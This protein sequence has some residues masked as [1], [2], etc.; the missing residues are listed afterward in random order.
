MK[1]VD[2]WTSVTYV[3]GQLFAD[4]WTNEGCK[5]PTTEK[6]QTCCGL[7]KEQG[8]PYCKGHNLVGHNARM[9]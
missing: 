9:R 4:W 8:T 6:P 5:W 7:P 2:D 1:I 3:E